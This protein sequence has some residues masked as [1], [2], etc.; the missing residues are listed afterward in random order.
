MVIG[1]I[2]DFL[3]SLCDGMKEIEAN[4]TVLI[5]AGSETTSTAMTAILTQLL[6]NPAALAKLVTEVRVNYE[7]EKDINI[8]TV[9]KLEYLT[10][11]IQEG[12]R[13]GPP[14]AVALPRITPR[15][16]AHICSQHVPGNVSFSSKHHV[17]CAH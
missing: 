14:A 8:N 1:Y 4:M 10:A 2:Q 3:H 16:G 12:I 13:M 9:A 7:S 15:E 11:V 17:R 6:Q 5:F